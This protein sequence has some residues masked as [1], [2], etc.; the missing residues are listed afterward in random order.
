MS[1]FEKFVTDGNEKVDLLAEEG[2]MLGEGFMAEMR[3]SQLSLF[4]V[5]LV[6]L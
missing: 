3:R 2:A 6:G 4:G 1:H 5:G